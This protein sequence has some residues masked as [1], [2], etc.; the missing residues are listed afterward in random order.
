MSK[1]VAILTVSIVTLIVAAFAAYAIY[2]LETPNPKP[3]AAEVKDYTKDLESIH[4]AI[5]AVN[6]R[7]QSLE[8]EN[9]EELHKIK[10]DL[11]QLRESTTQTQPESQLLFG[12]STDKN[13]YEKGDTIKI[14][15]QGILAQKQITIEVLSSFN[16]VITT[17]TIYSDPTGNLVYNLQLP[18]FIQ[19]GSYKIKATYDGKIDTTF[20]T[21]SDSATTESETQPS[22]KE[23]SSSGLTISL[24][25]E[26]YKPGEI[27]WVTGI[28]EPN[29]SV[30]LKMVGPDSKEQMANSST[31]DDGSFS[32]VFILADDAKSG[33]WTITAIQ[34]D[35]E[36]KISFK[37][38]N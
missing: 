5:Q 29:T 7:I 37:V 36:V 24:D 16:E 34:D 28:G 15:G 30:L 12:I 26:T 38:T 25:K 31:A 3:A 13:S 2:D 35:N 17:K 22:V 14:T 32:P 21:I 23:K 19:E 20:I 10:T 1:E 11:E 27:I 6:E 9:V 8:D 4:A 33:D 18:T